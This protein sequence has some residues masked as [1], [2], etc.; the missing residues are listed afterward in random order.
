M[1]DAQLA[2]AQERD[3]R[4]RD[5]EAMRF[6]H[7]CAECGAP[8]VVV[9]QWPGGSWQPGMRPADAVW[10]L[11]CGQD[12]SHLGFRKLPSLTQRY[13][14]GEALPLHIVNRI[15]AR[16]RDDV[17][18]GL[19]PADRQA[20][21][22]YQGSRALTQQQAREIL[23]KIWP[24][25]P[26]IEKVRAAMLCE[27][28]RLN[29]L[30]KHVF[31][32]PFEKKDKEGKVLGK[33]WT[34]V[35][36]ID[37]SRL[38]A[39]RRAPYS[40]IDGPRV[41]TEEE[42]MRIYGEVDAE[43]VVAITIVADGAGNRAPGYGKWPKKNNWGKANEPQGT[44]KGN[45]MLNMAMIRSERNALKRLRPA[46]MPDVEV[47]DAD[48][49][50]L[51]RIDG[52]LAQV[53]EDTAVLPDGAEAEAA[54][55]EEANARLESANDR[56]AEE[57]PPEPPPSST[58]S[59]PL[60]PPKPSCVNDLTKAAHKRYGLQPKQVYAILGVSSAVEIGPDLD[61]AWAKIVASQEE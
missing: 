60:A 19:V 3:D 58:K 30:M 5:L 55:E 16:R 36:G 28:Y 49:V 45:S 42:Q 8:V 54:I 22:R 53:P 37:A 14:R 21:A 59:E 44:E 6:T 15:E 2:E 27:S 34:T 43:S 47:I 4:R 38:L 56:I 17:T 13:Q 57:G 20:L 11:F 9:H 10:A 24:D 39:S 33:T 7:V 52:V 1:T 40:V 18:Q 29:P 61:A 35:M 12:R 46:E 25:A 41:M 32:I 48:Y 51:P 50:V 31:L 26:D 23:D